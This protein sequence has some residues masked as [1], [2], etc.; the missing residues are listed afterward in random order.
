MMKK[1]IVLI[2]IVV[3]MVLQGT[4]AVGA[5]S[6]SEQQKTTI[7]TVKENVSAQFEAISVQ[8]EKWKDTELIY[9]KALFDSDDQISAYKFLIK[10]DGNILGY[11]IANTLPSNNVI[12]YGQEC[13]LDEA[14]N[15]IEKSYKI[16]DEEQKVYYLGEL[17]YV[18]G[19]ES[20]EE[21]EIYID[22]STG[23]FEKIDKEELKQI[24]E[25]AN[26]PPDSGYNYIT[27]PQNYESGYNYSHLYGVTGWD[28]SYHTMSEFSSGGVC[29]PTAAT[30]LLFYWHTCR[31]RKYESLLNGTWQNTFNIL[32]SNMGTSEKYGTFDSK[33]APGLN[34]A[35]SATS[36]TRKS[37]S[38]KSKT[39]RKRPKS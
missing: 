25:G 29:Y 36:A 1:R 23:E 24:E 8:N 31:G 32:S 2:A 14:I 27:N 33:V 12:E 37:S 21:K 15:T 22:I 9:S 11:L 4:T 28:I 5:T 34:A 3:A 10:K 38:R 18:V 7:Q 6:L 30:N 16:E 19:A 20:A 17:N 13:F 26:N 39:L 35:T